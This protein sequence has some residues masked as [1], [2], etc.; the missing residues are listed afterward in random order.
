[1]SDRARV[2]GKC[3]MMCPEKERV[4]REKERRLSVFEVATVQDGKP[5][6]SAHLAVKEYVR[7]GAGHEFP[8]A[9]ELRPPPVLVQTVDHLIRNVADRQDHPWSVVYSFINDRIQAIRQ[10]ATYQ[11][12]ECSELEH[13]LELSIRFYLY[14]QYKL[15]CCS[16]DTFD[17]K[18]NMVQLQQCLVKLLRCPTVREDSLEEF[19]SY[20]LLINLGS[21]EAV[22]EI[23]NQIPNW[24]H[25]LPL[26]LAVS[27]S[28]SFMDNN[29]VRFFRLAKQLSGLQQCALLPY[30][31]T[32]RRR[33]LETLC[34]AYSSRNN[35][36]PVRL[37][38]QWLA[39]QDIDTTAEFCRQHN[40]EMQGENI[41][42][43]KGT[44]MC[45][46]TLTPTDCTIHEW[47]HKSL[48]PSTICS[49]SD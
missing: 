10:D 44:I 45:S 22:S 4:R 38:Q 12:L 23:V 32:I 14:S 49:S 8:E 25:S 46:Q 43:R 18:L 29:F 11:Q 33:A 26:K 9:N 24:Q 30:I 7:A 39:F 47:T 34:T 31:S 13:I 20:Y 3:V 35:P 40:V 1:M 48:K 19:Q 16:L 15:Y 36:F 41:V 37:L 42:F 17:P 2:V 28:V 21:T 27:V 6:T 5:R